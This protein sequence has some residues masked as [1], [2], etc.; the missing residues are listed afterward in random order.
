LI[1]NFD[2]N[3]CLFQNLLEPLRVP[4]ETHVP[5]ESPY[6][7]KGTEEQWNEEELQRAF[8][9]AAVIEVGAVDTSK[10]SSPFLSVSVGGIPGPTGTAPEFLPA[11]GE[12]W[13]LKVAKVGLLARKDDTVEG[14]KKATNRKWKTWSVILTGSQLLLFRDSSWA[15]SLLAQSKSD[16]PVIIPQ[17]SLFKP[18]ELLSVKDSIAI[19]DKSYTKVCHI[20]FLSTYRCLCPVIVSE[21][22]ALCLP[23]WSP[24]SFADLK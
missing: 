2:T 15:T 16:E 19:F 20:Y 6:S 4:V 8:A 1:S 21:Y 17:A 3:A 22:L 24:I 9:R 11:T 7:Y 5:L 13:T 12:L 23:R 14:G 10:S 18:D